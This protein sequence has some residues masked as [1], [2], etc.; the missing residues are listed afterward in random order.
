MQS[1]LLNQETL[2]TEPAR[3]RSHLVSA[4]VAV[5]VVVVVFNSSRVFSS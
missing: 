2:P 1:Q 4:W 5:V 3:S